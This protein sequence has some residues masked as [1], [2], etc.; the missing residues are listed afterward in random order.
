MYNTNYGFI[1]IKSLLMMNP[2]L[3]AI[4][5]EINIMESESGLAIELTVFQANRI[6]LQ[7]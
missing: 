4:L 6:Q 3:Q 7:C 5:D 1:T 2:Q